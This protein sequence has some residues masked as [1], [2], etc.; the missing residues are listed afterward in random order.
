MIANNRV[1]S[2]DGLEKLH[3]LQLFVADD[4]RIR[5]LPRDIWQNVRQVQVHGFTLII[6]IVCFI[7]THRKTRPL[8][9]NI[10]L[11]FRWRC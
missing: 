11:L 4:N 1:D 3:A 5:E 2:L 6:L 7:S 8:T 9:A 10:V